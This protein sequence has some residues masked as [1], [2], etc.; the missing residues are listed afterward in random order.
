[1]NGNRKRIVLAGGSGFL[2]RALASYFSKGGWEVVVLTRFPNTSE[3]TVREVAWDAHS[4]GPWQAELEEA[5]A[6]VNLTGKSVNCRYHAQNRQEIL[7]SRTNSTRVLGEAVGRCVNP[8]KVWLNAS[9]ATIYRHTFGPA[10]DE[11]GQVEPTPEAKDAFSL[12]VA[13]AWERVFEEA[14]TPRTRKV[15]LRTAMVL[16]TG[17]NSVF[18]MLRRLVCLGLGGKMGTG[19]QFVSWI[20]EADFCRAIE[21][22]LEHDSLDG[23][24]NV[25]APNP[26]PNHE[27][28]KT[29]RQVCG[30]PVGLPAATWMLEFGA[31]FLRT[32]TELIIKSRR[33]VPSRLLKSG[34]QFRF[35]GIRE[36]FDDL[37]NREKGDHAR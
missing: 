32:E 19:K 14:Q 7:E 11:G 13:E 20:H 34:F 21:W 37:R 31:F 9:T 33:V 2:G 8:P 24:V 3:R 29:L 26:L 5:V 36:A 16:G 23:I 18:P 15:A 28:M 10:W 35:P 4:A 25:A 30:V 12:E 17:Q 6:V 1:M 22:L 27:M